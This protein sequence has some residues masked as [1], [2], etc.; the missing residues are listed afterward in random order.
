LA[1]FGKPVGLYVQLTGFWKPVDLMCESQLAC[2]VSWPNFL[3]THVNIE[4]TICSIL[5]F[6]VTGLFEWYIKFWKTYRYGLSI[7]LLLLGIHIVFIIS[8]LFSFVLCVWSVD[9]LLKAIVCLMWI[10]QLACV[11]SWP[12]VEGHSVPGHSVPFVD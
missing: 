9:L 8:V 2:V 12:F 11:V 6:A 5:F 1:W 7:L 10:S 4:L 3:R